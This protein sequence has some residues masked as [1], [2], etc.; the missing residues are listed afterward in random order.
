MPMEDIS[1]VLEWDKI[2]KI[3]SHAS[4]DNR[5][6][7]MILTTAAL[8]SRRM[9]EIVGR[10]EMMGRR[11]PLSG[12][13]GL[14]VCD[15][16]FRNEQI[17]WTIEK[18]F[19][20]QAHT[21]RT[22]KVK[23]AHPELLFLLR[24]WIYENGLKEDEKMFNI[25]ERRVNQILHRY[26][27]DLGI[28]EK[29][30]LCHA[31]RHGFGLQ[32]AKNMKNPSEAVLLQRIL[33]HTRIDQTFAYIQLGSGESKKA[34]GRLWIGAKKREDEKEGLTR[35]LLDPPGNDEQLLND[36]DEEV[37]E[38][39]EAGSSERVEEDHV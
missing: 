28:T 20:D 11:G 13:P 7:Y 36:P 8:T 31:F 27:E 15:I 17:K 1:L 33:D 2:E 14:R 12:V 3:L 10:K 26:C 34:L 4:Q 18:R 5:R 38:E 22:I 32:F 16:D 24:K 6:N 9:G 35:R 23:D 25:T 30:R 29:R 21:E 39:P 19:K 37:H